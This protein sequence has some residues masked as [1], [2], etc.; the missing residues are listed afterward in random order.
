[1]GGSGGLSRVSRGKSTKATSVKEVTVNGRKYVKK[2]I[3][4]SQP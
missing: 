4:F 3:F 2:I 1:M